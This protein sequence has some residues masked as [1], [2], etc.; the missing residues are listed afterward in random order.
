MGGCSGHHSDRD[1]ILGLSR[2]NHHPHWHDCGGCG[3]CGWG[4]GSFGYYFDIQGFVGRLWR[5]H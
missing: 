3:C 1:W 2:H 5:A 4:W